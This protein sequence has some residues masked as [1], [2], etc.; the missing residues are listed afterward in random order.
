MWNSL[1]GEGSR[2]REG[3]EVVLVDE[4]KKVLQIVLATECTY[5]IIILEK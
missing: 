1:E 4:L 2:Q 5:S 3:S